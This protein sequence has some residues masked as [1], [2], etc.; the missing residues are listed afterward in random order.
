MFEKKKNKIIILGKNGFIASSIISELKLNKFRFKSFSKKELNLLAINDLKKLEN[1]IK[2]D[3]ILLFCSA[4]APVKNFKM[5][6]QNM[7]MSENFLKIKNLKKLSA[8]CYLSSDAVFSDT[9]FKI[10]ENSSKEPNNLHGIMHLTREKLFKLAHKNVFC[11]RPTLVYGENDPHCSYGPNKFLREAIINKEIK[12]F[13]NGEELRD[14]IYVKDVARLF[15]ILIKKN[16]FEDFNF[17]TGKEKNFFNIANDIKNKFKNI[18]ITKIP[19]IGLMPHNGYRVFDNKKIKKLNFK[20]T[21]FNEYL[22]NYE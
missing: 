19:R 14:H 11:I 1:T 18:K 8:I 10:T 4:L 22:D 15:T 3:D 20:M 5:F 13:G 21:K 9:K 7:K 12:I 2:K 16:L 17:V 6:F